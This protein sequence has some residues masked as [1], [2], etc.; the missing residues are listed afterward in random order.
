MSYRSDMSNS[1]ITIT[2]QLVIYNQFIGEWASLFDFT[3][4][5]VTIY[6]NT[7]KDNGYLSFEKLQG[8]PESIYLLADL[9]T[10]LPY[11]RY[12]MDKAQESGVFMFYYMTV[13]MESNT[14]H[15]IYNNSF[16]NIFCQRGCAYMVYGDK[17]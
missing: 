3:G 16:E 4:G 15:H 14:T 7:F 1:T 9:A 11:D 17:Y 2:G 6:E 10:S 8:N 5:Q 12:S 13:P